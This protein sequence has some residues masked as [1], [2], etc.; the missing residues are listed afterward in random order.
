MTYVWNNL[1]PRI[2]HRLM[3]VLQSWLGTPYMAGQQA[4]GIGV[5]CVQLVGAVYDELY[6]LPARTVIPRLPP[7]IGIHN[8]RAGFRTAKAIRDNFPSRVAR[9]AIIEPGDVLIVRGTGL[10]RGPRLMG[11]TMIAGV[12]AFTAFHA[13]PQ[14]GV[15]LG[16][17]TVEIVRIYRPLEKERWI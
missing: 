8:A 16:A 11:H 14:V 9:G 3:Q 4:R 15:T 6:R 2:E 13:V 1:D 5:D 12:K 10:S 17:T 7:T